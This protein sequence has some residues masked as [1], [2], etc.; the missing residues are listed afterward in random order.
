MGNAQEALIFSLSGDGVLYNIALYC[1]TLHL[2]IYCDSFTPM[3]LVLVVL[4]LVE[5]KLGSG[6]KNH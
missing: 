4:V 3:M 2:D 6:N 1:M 5:G